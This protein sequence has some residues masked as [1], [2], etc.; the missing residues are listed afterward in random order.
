MKY[1]NKNYIFP[2][3]IVVLL[4]SISLFIYKFKEG[5]GENGWIVFDTKQLTTQTGSGRKKLGQK[6]KQN[7][8]CKGWNR[9]KGLGNYNNKKDK[10]EPMCC[11]PDKRCVRYGKFSGDYKSRGCELDPGQFRPGN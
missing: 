8:N 7:S 2:I 1:K 11:G 4:I 9:D 6:C 3:I 10:E 5:L